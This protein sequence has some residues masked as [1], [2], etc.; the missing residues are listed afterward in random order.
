MFSIK[1]FDRISPAGLSI[2][3]RSRYNIDSSTTT[4]DAILLRSR[5]LLEEMI[6][7]S[8]KAIA[9]AGA[10]VNNIPVD[11]CT[12]QGIIVF[13]TPGANANSVKEL[14]IAGLLLSSRRIHEGMNW[15][16]N[17]K[18]HSEL[19]KQVEKNK[20]TFVGNEISGKSIG[21]I[22]LGAIG[23]LVANTVVELG[24]T[25]YGYDP[26]IS[27]DA[28]WGL[29]RKVKRTESLNQ[30]MSSCDYITLHVPLTPDTE[31]LVNMENLGRAKKGLRIL[32]FSRDGLVDG[33]AV[34]SSLNKGI[35][36]RYITDF[37]TPELMGIEGV[38][39]LPHLGASTMEAE[40]NCAVMAVRQLKNFLENG[41]IVNSVN[42]PDCSLDNTGVTRLLVAN[43][44][45][46]NML[47]QILEI[48][49]H[50]NLNV[51]EMVNKHRNGVAYNIIDISTP[52]ISESVLSE[53]NNIEGVIMTRQ[54]GC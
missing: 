23:V 35:I 12:R 47:S 19:E 41:S 29:S 1:T 38:M 7:D 40:E 16:E 4:P 15:L 53:L 6:G 9:R 20:S 52:V 49:A 28:A 46:P 24:M 21:I 5:C 37:P 18:P 44:N 30:I 3:D 14:V 32:N 26:F 31:G 17:Q 25:T 2:L 51:E 11:F 50:K 54:I 8:V 33:K 42:F 22:G 48:L 36:N 34:E 39:S 27:I 10:G 43:L 13:N 45:V